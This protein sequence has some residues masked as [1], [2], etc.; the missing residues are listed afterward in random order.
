MGSYTVSSGKADE[1]MLS[2]ASA[3]K[4]AVTVTVDN[5]TYHLYTVAAK[6][7][8]K[9]RKIKETVQNTITLTPGQHEVTVY[10]TMTGNEVFHKTIFVSV[11]EHKIIE[12]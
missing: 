3:E 8:K 11:Q 1:G 9:A 4:T 12:L 2:F 6:K 10:V 5:A 7:W